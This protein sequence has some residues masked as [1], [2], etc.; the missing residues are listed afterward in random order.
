MTIDGSGTDDE[1]P[2]S[3]DAPPKLDPAAPDEPS[4]ASEPDVPGPNGPLGAS[5]PASVKP[6]AVGL[7]A[8]SEAAMVTVPALAAVP[9][10]TKAFWIIWFA[11][12][13]APA[14]TTVSPF[15]SMAPTC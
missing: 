15:P 13:L 2:P 3:P 14:L 4:A 5:E 11:V 9:P 1:L 8:A 10:I 7:P 6:L 12:R